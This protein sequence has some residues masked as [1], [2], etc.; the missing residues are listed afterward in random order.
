MQADRAYAVAR[1]VL[2]VVAAALGSDA[3]ERRYVTT[4]Q[5][6]FDCEQ[7]VVSIDRILGHQGNPGVETNDV[8]RCLTMRA[9][10]LS[11]WTCRCV[12]VVADDG[13]P[14]PAEEI[15]AA[16]L[17]VA[18]DPIRNLDAILAAYNAG[19]LGHLWGLVFLDWRALTAQG[20]IAGGAQRLR[21]DLT[22]PV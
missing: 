20:G 14:P 22:A 2:D 9:V 5:P 8:V 19:T 6:A 16:G 15:D 13:T 12:P 7:L 11:V 4:G 10:E 17:E 18:Q 21:I 1:N 3:P